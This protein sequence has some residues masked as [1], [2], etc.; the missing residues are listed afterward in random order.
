MEYSNTR[1]FLHLFMGPG[2]VEFLSDGVLE[3]FVTK[4]PVGLFG[5]G[6]S[7]WHVITYELAIR[8]IFAVYCLKLPVIGTYA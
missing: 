3:S 6:R 2:V 1:H 5:G 7:P 4:E 8:Y